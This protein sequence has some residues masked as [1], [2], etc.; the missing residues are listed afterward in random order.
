[1]GE[2]ELVEGVGA[3]VAFGAPGF[4][5]AGGRH[6]ASVRDRNVEPGSRV[7]TDGWTGYRGIDMLGYFHEPRSQRAARRRGEDIDGLLPGVHRIASLAEQWLLGPIKDRSTR[8]TCR[9]T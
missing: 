6:A 4:F 9:A 2:D 3:D 1:M 7:I 8:H 5:T